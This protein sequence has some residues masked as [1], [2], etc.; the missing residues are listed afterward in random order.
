MT[1]AIDIGNSNIVIGGFVN[2]KIR[3]TA[4]LA[5]NAKLEADQFAMDLAGVFGLHRVDAS[6]IDGIVLSSVVPSLT[7]I[8]QQALKHFTP[9]PVH[10]LSL[11][12]ANGI[13]VDIENPSEL[14]MDILATAIAVRHTHAL[15]C[16][17][18]D[19]GTA[20]KLSALDEHGVLRGVSIAPGL[21]VSLDALL[22]RASLLP[23]ISLAPPKNAIGRNST[24]SIQSGV[25]LGSASMLDGLLAA[26]EKEL[27]SLRS[28]VATGGAAPL[29]VPYC[30]ADIEFCEHLLLSGL[31]FAHKAAYSPT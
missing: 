16:V 28:V 15:P 17:V 3:F 21:F 2:G 23:G 29:V 11:Q 18:I 1:L 27:G 19:M 14:G 30:K 6:C 24:E 22:N 4:R 13:K 12:D 26:F 25:L 10:V 7:L 31:Y 5:T 9:L 20:T 8:F